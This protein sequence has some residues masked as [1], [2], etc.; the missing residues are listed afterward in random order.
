M[1]PKGCLL[2]AV[3]SAAFFVA[4]AGEA[5]AQNR[6]SE[7]ENFRNT[8]YVKTDDDVMKTYLFL[9]DE[10]AGEGDFP[11]C[12]ANLMRA[13]RRGGDALVS[14]GD[15]TFLTGRNA[16][17]KRL[18]SLPPEAFGLYLEAAAEE[19]ERMLSSALEQRAEELLRDG[20]ARFPFTPGAFKALRMLGGLS[21][22]RGDCLEAAG[23]YRRYLDHA[24]LAGRVGAAPAPAEQAAVRLSL[25]LALLGCGRLDDAAPFAPTGTVLV[26]GREM[27]ARELADTFAP[28]AGDE[29]A[30]E[31]GWPTRGGGRTRARLPAFDC[32]SLRLL[33]SHTL[34]KTEDV[35][36][37]DEWPRPVRER[38]SLDAR[39]LG[40]SV[41]PV[42]HDGRLYVFNERG[43]H[44]LDLETGRPAF[45]PLFWDWSLIFG[46]REPDLENVSYSGT[47]AGGVF[48]VA[49]NHHGSRSGYNRAEHTGTLLALDLARDG[50]CIWKRGGEED[51]DVEETGVENADIGTAEVEDADIGAAEV[52]NADIATSFFSGLAFSGAPVVLEGRV[53]LM[54][55]RHTATVAE[56]WVLCFDAADGALLF[57]RFLCS[58]VEIVKFGSAS[59]LIDPSLRDKVELGAPIVENGGVLFCLTNLGVAAAVDAFSGEVLWLFR[60][61][62]I[63]AQDPDAYD[64]AFF[65]DTGGWEDSLPLFRDGRFIMA[66]ADSRYLYTLAPAPDRDGF[67]VLDDPVENGRF[68][69]FIGTDGT[70]FYFTAREGGRN[71]I[72]AAERSGALVWET[73]LFTVEDRI[74]GQPLLTKTALFVPTLRYIYRVD[75]AAEGLITHSFPAPVP[76]DKSSEKHQD[77]RSPLFGNIITTKDRLISVS[78]RQVLV[79]AP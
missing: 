16:A 23:R 46:D 57:R 44:A 32:R 40:A 19:S 47:A 1:I 48:F 3:F 14:F 36:E 63:F 9:A 12:V 53:Y 13:L 43:L 60:Y 77:L 24:G 50:A 25:Y 20:A 70:L 28:L 56:A 61:N 6:V 5:P 74:T 31:G 38:A 73:E 29:D 2:A 51:D 22:E 65:F 42:V 67:I 30:A 33:W 78:D 79:F 41:Y 37:D 15:R 39:R 76:A 72:A 35:D 49:L 54:A 64:R 11:E 69:S 10:A 52:E 8:S 18:A 34:K 27:D 66:P 75:L 58:G 55:T 59:D 26:G 71:F 68:I 7:R 62:R 17:L 4:L 45:G 21:R